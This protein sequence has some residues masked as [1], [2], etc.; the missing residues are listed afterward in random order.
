[1]NAR[2]IVLVWAA[3]FLP[4]VALAWAIWTVLPR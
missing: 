2:R 1:M 3:I 4:V